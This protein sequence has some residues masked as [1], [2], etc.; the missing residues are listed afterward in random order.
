MPKMQVRIKYYRDYKNVDK[1]K[2]Q[3]SYFVSYQTS[4]SKK[5]ANSFEQIF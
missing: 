5:N 3:K 2:F 4:S 1:D